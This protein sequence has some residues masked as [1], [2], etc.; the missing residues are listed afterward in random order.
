MKIGRYFAIKFLK[1]CYKSK[2]YAK[3]DKLGNLPCDAKGMY[4]LTLIILEYCN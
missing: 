2:K 4:N 1:K 3:F